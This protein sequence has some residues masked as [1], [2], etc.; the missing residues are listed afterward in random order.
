MLTG[1]WRPAVMEGVCVTEVER[2]VVV[3]RV[4]TM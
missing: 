3:V 1:A 4:G 2:Y